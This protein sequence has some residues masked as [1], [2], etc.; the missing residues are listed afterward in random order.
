V[1][2]KSDLAAEMRKAGR[3]AGGSKKTRHD[4]DV[5]L[6]A[7]C[8]WLWA[9][10]YQL[11]SV[12]GLRVRHID[13]YISARIADGICLRS[14][15]NIASTIRCALRG[16]GRTAFANSTEISNEA[17]GISGGSRLGTKRPISNIEYQEA[18]RRAL[19]LDEGLAAVLGLERWIGL[20]GRESVMAAP[21]LEDWLKFITAGKTKIGIIHGT[22]GGRARDTTLH[23]LEEATKAIQFASYIAS[24]RGGV[25]ISAKNLG[26]A[27]QYYHRHAHALGL[28]G[29][30]APH[31]LRYAY[32]CDAVE[33]YK[34]A[35]H[36]EREA[37]ALAAQDLGHGSGRGRLLREIYGRR[38]KPHDSGN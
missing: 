36:N 22:K 32:A 21:S 38:P 15:Q 30:I 14:A 11:S 6:T 33:S 8:V 16:A 18:Y 3:L 23:C 12:V 17:L 24:Q 25:L 1:S 5:M 29:E 28:I 10:G 13:E 20:R 31:S 26:T 2:K 27:L 7:F 4:R 19:V 37:Q 9:A 35:G 34:R